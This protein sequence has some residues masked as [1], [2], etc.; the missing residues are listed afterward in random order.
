MPGQDLGGAEEF[1]QLA[2]PQQPCAPEGGFVGRIGA[3]QRTGMEQ[4]PGPELVER[5][6]GSACV[7]CRWFRPMNSILLRARHA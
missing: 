2:H 1:P 3:G 5:L 6:D 7:H 4:V